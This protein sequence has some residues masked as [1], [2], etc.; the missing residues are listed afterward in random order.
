MAAKLRKPGVQRHG[1]IHPHGLAL[2]AL[3]LPLQ[4]RL[5]R[6]DPATFDVV[7]TDLFDTVLMRDLSL[8]D[9]RFDEAAR[10][11]AGRLGLHP[12][13]LSALRRSFHRIAYNAVAAARPAGDASLEMNCRTV[14]AA[15][16]RGDAA[17]VLREAEVEMD[18]RHLSP[19]RPLIAAYAA[20]AA[21]GKRVIATTDTYY[22]ADEIR[23]M[24]GRVIGE[25]PI[26]QVYASCDLGLTKHAG[27]IFA[28][29]ARREGVCPTRILHLGDNLDADVRQAR[30]AGWQA[31][32]LPRG[33]VWR[34]LGKLAVRLSA[35]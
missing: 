33:V 27:A 10:D 12:G 26:S 1:T 16:G 15:M 25:H 3:A 6:I 20:L 5:R 2:K 4:D 34:R 31:V 7:S 8:E 19:N 23:H 29:V 9:R 24:L 35:A 11:A 22:S 17:A 21:Q 14:A 30:A 18:I 13:R 32:H 28:E